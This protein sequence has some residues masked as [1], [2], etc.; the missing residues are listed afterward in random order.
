MFEEAAGCKQLEVAEVMAVRRSEIVTVAHPE[1][2]KLDT[3]AVELNVLE[4]RPR[5][6]EGKKD[7]VGEERKL[8]E[9]YHM[10]N[11]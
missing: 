5:R 9:G 2:E 1:M 10:R 4:V 3:Y 6:G 8:T 11:N 7:I